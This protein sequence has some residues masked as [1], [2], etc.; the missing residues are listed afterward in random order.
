MSRELF[1]ADGL[2]EAA[3]RIRRLEGRVARLEEHIL[4][5][6][7]ALAGDALARE[8]LVRGAL[9][10]LVAPQGQDRP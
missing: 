9:G 6:E 1:H 10:T 8:R 7:S 3:L 5:L 2:A 4:R